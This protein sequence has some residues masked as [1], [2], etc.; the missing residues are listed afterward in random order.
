MILLK[1]LLKKFLF[2]NVNNLKQTNIFILYSIF[3]IFIVILSIIF[4]KNFIF[5]YPHIIDDDA[6][7][8]Y[9]NIPFEYGKLL[10]NLVFNN[11]YSSTIV[12]L[13]NDVEFY[14][15]RMPILPFIFYAISLVSYKLYFLIIAKNTIFFSI[16]FFTLFEFSKQ[17]NFNTF[18]FLILNFIFFYNLY[19]LKIIFNIVFADFII[20]ILLPILFLLSI[21]KFKFKYYYIGLVIFIL[22]LSKANMFPICVCLGIYF[23]LFEKKKFPIISVLIAIIS[24]GYFGYIK[25]NTFAFGPKILS[26]GSHALS[27]SFNS[28][29]RKFYPLTSV[30]YI[31]SCDLSNK[32][33]LKYCENIPQKIDN[34]WDYYN[35]YNAKNKKYFKENKKIIIEDFI[36]KIKTIF[37]NFYEDG[38]IHLKKVSPEKN[39]DLFIF[40]NKLIMLIAIFTAV[41]VVIIKKFTL[42]KIKTEII[43]LIILLSSLPSFLLGWALNRHLVYLFLISHIY[44]FLKYNFKSKQ[45][46]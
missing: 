39:F 38:Q 6:N 32:N 10:E 24:W 16:L 18:I 13:G 12:I 25:T 5:L 14:Q 4:Y 21:S 36:L 42:D 8:I 23:L 28:D 43:F 46:D 7:I 44:L 33:K 9:K 15:N 1:N 37:L 40:F 45:N 30:D 35:F 19:N 3:L 26:T 41:S 34:E 31:E 2:I 22:Y 17:R 20:S 27:L 11:K 29:F